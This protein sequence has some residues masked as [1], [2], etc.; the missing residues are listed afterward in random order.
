MAKDDI[1]DANPGNPVLQVRIQQKGDPKADQLIGVKDDETI[2]FGSPSHAFILKG[3]MSSG[4]PSV[5]IYALIGDKHVFLETSGEIINGL[6]AAI[7]GAS[8]GKIM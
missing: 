8:D 4:K 6:A 1:F 7:R 2:W 3:A 5:T